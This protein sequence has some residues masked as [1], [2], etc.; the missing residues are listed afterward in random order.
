MKKLICTLLA[1]IMVLSMA[2]CSKSEILAVVEL[3]DLDA[4]EIFV[5]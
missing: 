1:L 4:D 5:L 3:K 2:A